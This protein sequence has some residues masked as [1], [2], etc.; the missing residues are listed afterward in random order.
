M[1]YNILS[2]LWEQKIE[3]LAGLFSALA[4]YSYFYKANLI[5]KR[6]NEIIDIKSK[7]TQLKAVM[8]KMKDK[9]RDEL[10]HSILENKIDRIANEV[11]I[12]NRM[13][14]VQLNTEFD[15]LNIRL[16][17][18]DSFIDKT[19]KRI[20]KLENDTEFIRASKRWKWVV[21]LALI[22]LITTVNFAEIR[23]FLAKLIPW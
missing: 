7:I 9:S 6:R 11:K 20:E 3:I 16:D 12:N 15:V 18:V 1:V 8:A 17:K 5:F 10:E 14:M 13:L 19:E 4:V 22:G 23:K 2:L 21:G